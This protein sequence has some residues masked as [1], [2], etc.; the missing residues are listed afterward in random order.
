MA[1]LS[2]TYTLAAPGGTIVFNN[3]DL[4][5][6]TDLYWILEIEG[7]DGAE[8]R[9][10]V[11]NAPQADGGIIHTGWKTPRHITFNGKL[12]IFSVPFGWDCTAALN[13]MEENLRIATDSMIR[14][15]GTLTWQPDGLPTHSL[16]VRR[17]IKVDYSPQD[18]YMTR[19]FVFGLV[20]ADP[21]WTLST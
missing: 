6:G 5:D 20:A 7:L 14:A 4:N 8:A 12:M 1:D 2:T 18:N 19:G 16:T 15:D 3:G 9:L 17:E 21:D 10:Q 11:D 13:T